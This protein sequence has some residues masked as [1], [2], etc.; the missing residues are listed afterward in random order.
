MQLL[1]L[2]MDKVAELKDGSAF[3]EIALITNS[4]RL[5]LH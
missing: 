4:K 5:A 2:Y 3:G 1:Y